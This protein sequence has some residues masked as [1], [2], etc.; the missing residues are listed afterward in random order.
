[1][2]GLPQG[3]PEAGD[4]GLDNNEIRERIYWGG[5]LYWL[6]A[7]VRIRARTDNRR[8]VDDVI[9]AILAAGG[10]G[11]VNW[12]LDRVLAA[13]EKATG[14]TVLKDLYEEL[15]QKPGHVDLNDLWKRLGVKYQSGMVSFDNSAPWAKIRESITAPT[16]RVR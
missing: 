13:S 14:T 12:P 2:E 11:S 4:G 9:R 3:L 1:M 5:N 8:S 7:D 15:G 16:G 10:D 6:L